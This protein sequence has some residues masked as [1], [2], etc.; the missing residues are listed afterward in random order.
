MFTECVL[1][2]VLCWAPEVCGGEN[3][4]WVLSAWSLRSAGEASYQ[5]KKDGT[6]TSAATMAD[7]VLGECSRGEARRPSL[8]NDDRGEAGGRGRESLGKRRRKF[9]SL[10]KGMCKDATVPNAGYTQGGQ[11]GKGGEESKES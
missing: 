1:C 7:R 2:A 11:H 8:G 10:G 4:A 5:A 3:Q 6:R 9:S